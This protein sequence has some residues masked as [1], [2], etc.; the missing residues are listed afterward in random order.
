VL[1]SYHDD[2]RIF[3]AI[4]AGALSYLLKDVLP[5]DLAG[6]IRAAARGEAVLHPLVATRVLQDVRGA[7][8]GAQ[9]LHGTHR[10]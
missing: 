3:P 4:K 8:G 9:P 2:V 10:P 6:A 5:K 1:T 7:R